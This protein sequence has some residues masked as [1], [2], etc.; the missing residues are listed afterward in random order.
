[1]AVTSPDIIELAQRH[2]L[3][4]GRA[5]ERVSIVPASTDVAR[6]LRIAPGTD[7]VKLDRVTE[8]ADGTPIEWRVAFTRKSD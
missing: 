4:L 5:S 8:T 6:H 1:M 3:T 2:G 7:V